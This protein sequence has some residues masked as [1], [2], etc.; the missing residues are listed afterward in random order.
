MLKKM[1]LFIIP[2]CLIISEAGASEDY[3]DG[4]ARFI[5]DTPRELHIEVKRVRANQLDCF[6]MPKRKWSEGDDKKCSEKM[7][8]SYQNIT[9]LPKG[10]VMNVCWSKNLFTRNKFTMVE[11]NVTYKD[12]GITRA[13]PKG[14][15]IDYIFSNECSCAGVDMMHG[16]D[17]TT[18]KS[19]KCGRYWSNCYIKFSLAQQKKSSVQSWLKKF[20]TK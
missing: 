3:C 5:N 13:G 19:S 7:V 11:F 15:I 6:I 16:G 8:F 9:L 14:T 1:Y 12:H 20:I 17:Q 10:G 2:C 4:E 18:I